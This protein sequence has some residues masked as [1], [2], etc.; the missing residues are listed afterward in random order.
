MEKESIW[1]G[2]HGRARGVVTGFHE[3]AKHW[4]ETFD[5]LLDGDHLDAG[6]TFE[7]LLLIL[8]NESDK[9][10]SVSDE[11]W[12]LAMGLLRLDDPGSSRVVRQFL[13]NHN[14]Q[15]RPGH[16]DLT[17][18][19]TE[20]GQVRGEDPRQEG[21]VAPLRVPLPYHVGRRR[22]ARSSRQAAGVSRTR[23]DSGGATPRGGSASR[24]GDD[25]A[26][27]KRSEALMSFIDAPW[28]HALVGRAHRGRQVATSR[29][30][31]RDGDDRGES[32]AADKKRSETLMSFIKWDHKH[33]ERDDR[34][35]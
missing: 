21:R 23:G 16:S 34:A 9:E 30:V 11:S 24:P 32:D 4:G 19:A 2:E 6:L 7:E 3:S 12:A 14:P 35:E 18:W 10:R 31:E 17:E 26:D 20:E 15:Q 28:D 13:N 1:E 8:A 5:V 22:R 27:R 29:S 33:R 25:R